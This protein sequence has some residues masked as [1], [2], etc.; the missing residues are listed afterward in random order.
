MIVV[1]L[2]IGYPQTVHQKSMFYKQYEVIMFTQTAL[3]SLFQV[4]Y[5]YY[6]QS[7]NI[8]QLKSSEVKDLLCIKSNKITISITN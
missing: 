3:F 5:M 8:Y 1:E 2:F 4:L 7:N 6:R